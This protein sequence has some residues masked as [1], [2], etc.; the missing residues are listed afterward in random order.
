MLNKRS[1]GFPKKKIK[2]KT[3]DCTHTHRISPFFRCCMSKTPVTESNFYLCAGYFFFF[4]F[5]FSCLF[6]VSELPFDMETHY[7]CTFFCLFLEWKWLWV[8]NL[9]WFIGDG[10]D[11]LD[12]VIMEISAVEIRW[13]EEW[14]KFFQFRENLDQNWTNLIQ[15]YQLTELKRS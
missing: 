12:G 6:L 13:Q 5:P 11:L 4:W 15:Y 2:H 3:A 10:C 1:S 7:A 14:R 8:E 9:V